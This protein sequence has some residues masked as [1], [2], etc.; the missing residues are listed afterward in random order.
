MSKYIIKRFL[1]LIP[2]LLGA[3]FFVFCIMDMSPGDPAVIILGPDASPENI[4]D[5]KVEL[6]L[7]KP[8]MVRYFNF[9]GNLIKGDLGTSYKNNISVMDQI[10]DKLPNTFLLA[11]SGMLVAVVVGIPV[12]IIS[13]KKQY[14]VFDNVTMVVTLILAASPAFWLGLMLVLLFSLNLGWFPSSGMGSG[15][16]GVIKSLILPAI[17]VGSNTAALVARM[18]RSSMLEVIRQDYIDTARAKGLKESVI[19]YK[20]MLKNALI[21][22]ITVVGLQFGVLLGGSVMTETVFSWPGVGRFV[23]EAIKTKDIPSVLGS[24]VVLCILFSFVN[25]FVDILYAYVDPRIKSQYKA[26]R[27]SK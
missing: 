1:M 5:L 3:T 26:G 6:G 23:V 27:S 8:L 14:S 12:G 24:V 7:D 17:T 21:P 19:T 16:G 25:L 11:L 18:T 15:F 22:I 9:I 10:R 13:A 2:V 4:A 20:H